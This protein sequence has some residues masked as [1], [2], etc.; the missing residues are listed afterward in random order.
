MGGIMVTITTKERERKI[1]DKDYQKQTQKQAMKNEW[2]QT[3][4]DSG[5]E[6]TCD[7]VKSKTILQRKRLNKLANEKRI[8][9]LKFEVASESD[10]ADSIN[11][12]TIDK[13]TSTGKNS[14]DEQTKLKQNSKLKPGNERKPNFEQGKSSTSSSSESNLTEHASET[15]SISIHPDDA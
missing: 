11:E 7:S 1:Q 6:N 5:L 3:S 8:I 2:N 10:S 9:K 14:C 12:S 15:S 13:S 4:D